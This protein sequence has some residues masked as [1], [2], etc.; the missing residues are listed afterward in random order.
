MCCG[1]IRAGKPFLEKRV[2]SVA[3]GQRTDFFVLWPSTRPLARPDPKGAHVK[4]EREILRGGSSGHSYA[5]VHNRRRFAT[6]P[7]ICTGPRIGCMDSELTGTPQSSELPACPLRAVFAPF[8]APLRSPRNVVAVP[9]MMT[10]LGN[11]YFPSSVP[12]F[13]GNEG[14]SGLLG[15]LRPTP[16]HRCAF[17]GPTLDRLHTAAT[18]EIASQPLCLAAPFAVRGPS[19]QPDPRVAARDRAQRRA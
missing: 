2:N 18:C 9:V 6:W 14:L 10:L 19:A 7:A 17:C 5:Y 15:P 4:Q 12:D 8:G 3:L 16:G 13:V 1:L 11:A